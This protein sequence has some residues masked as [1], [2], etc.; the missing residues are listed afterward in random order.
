MRPRFAIAAAMLLLAHSAAGGVIDPNSFDTSGQTGTLGGSSGTWTFDTD[1]LEVRLNGTR[2]AGG[3]LVSQPNGVDLAVFP[4]ENISITGSAAVSFTGQRPIAL[5]S[6][7]GV[8]IQP[9]INIGGIPQIDNVGGFRGGFTTRLDKVINGIGIHE[10]YLHEGFGPGGGKFSDDNAGGTFDVFSTGG[11]FG[12]AGGSGLNIFEE[13]PGGFAYGNLLASIEGGSGGASTSLGNEVGGGGGGG[14]AIVANGNVTVGSINADG[15]QGGLNDFGGGGAG[16]GILISGATVSYTSLSARGGTPSAGTGIGGGGG[17]LALLGIASYSFGSLVGGVNVDGGGSDISQGGV[18]ITRGGA[19]VITVSPQTFIATDNRVLDGS[20]LV[21]PGGGTTPTYEAEVR[22]NLTVS[23]GSTVTLGKNQPL[24]KLIGP[25]GASTAQ[26]QISAGGLFDTASFS[27]RVGTLLGSG[28]LRLSDGGRLTIDGTTPFYFYGTISGQGTLAVSPDA[29]FN[30]YE[31]VGSGYPSWTGAAEVA[32]T[33]NISRGAFNAHVSSVGN[34]AVLKLG[35]DLSSQVDLGGNLSQFRGTIQ[36]PNGTVHVAAV[37]ALNTPAS[38]VFAG[39]GSPKLDVA[40]STSVV[41]LV[42]GGS[43]SAAI[44]LGGGT[45][46]ISGLTNGSYGG[47][48]TG[49]GSIV[50]D[51]Y[52]AQAFYGNLSYTGA[53][54]VHA[55]SLQIQSPLGSGGTVRI[56][57]DGVL[58]ASASIARPIAGI[59]PTSVIDFGTNSPVSLGSATSFLGFVNEG[60]LRVG[61]HSV[62]VNSAGAARPGG[63]STLGGF[64]ELGENVVPGTLSIPNGA[65]V[66]FGEAI[67]GYGTINTPNTLAKRVVINGVAQGDSAANPLTFTGYVKGTGSFDNVTFTGT[68]SPGLSPA[69]I[70][71]GSIMLAP[72]STLEIELGGLTA[73]SG[74]DKIEAAGTLSVGGVLSVTLL[75]GFVPALGNSFDILDWNSLSG[76]FSSLSLPALGAGLSWNTSQLY[77]TGT[78]SV[79]PVGV[80]GDYNNNGVVDAADYVLWRNGGPLANEVDTPGVVNAA[81]YT[82]WRARFGNTSGSGAGNAD[83]ATTVPEPEGLVFLL[84]MSALFPSRGRRIGGPVLEKALNRRSS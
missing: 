6:K 9:T 23:A 19:G 46:T 72:T 39:T 53:T 36:I 63:L 33:L 78:L 56:D 34:A 35:F 50:K 43:S 49:N 5:A 24:D 2:V 70:S 67:A 48:I 66:D 77:T 37:G 30:A 64:D 10:A 25:G 42:S 29:T 74:Y 16:G 58:Y 15:T 44:N 14:L 41:G 83:F 18:T 17:R 75:G 40:G 81:D 1:A 20:L 11:G 47:A 54:V 57:P 69:I 73:G 65:I 79:V 27:Q 7:G 45:L 12:G 62:T 82:A 38:I 32:G 61:A 31:V 71:G 4:F 80:A 28:A 52:G 13:V 60:Q 84:G 76:T 51:G 8:L 26:L 3:V 21:K 55:G 22:R 68:F 59:G